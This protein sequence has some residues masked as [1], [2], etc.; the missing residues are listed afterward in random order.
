MNVSLPDS[1]KA[2]VDHQVLAGGYGTSSEYVRE[3][4]R[5]DQDRTRLRNLLLEGAAAKPGE[6]AD[7]AYFEGVREG[8]RRRAKT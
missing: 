8:I 7:A 4:I 2:Y 1:L 6:V 3:L 5:R